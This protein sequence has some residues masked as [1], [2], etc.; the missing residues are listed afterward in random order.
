MAIITVSRQMG[1]GG[2]PI[3]QSIAKA[4]R[5]AYMDKE[6]LLADLGK[7]GGPWAAWEKEMDEVCPTLWERFDRSFA[8]LVALVERSM[9]EA[10]LENNVV[11]V[12]RGAN[13]LLRGIP[14]AFHMQ[15]VG[16]LD[17]RVEWVM[18]HYDVPRDAAVK[19]IRKIDHDRGCYLQTVYHVD[20]NNP[21]E[22][23]AV[24]DVGMQSQEQIV[25]SVL[26]RIGS[27]NSDCSDAARLILQQRVQAA[28]LKAAIL[29]DAHLFVPTLEVRH[30]G[31]ALEVSGVIHNAKQYKQIEEIVHRA[32]PGAPVDLSKLHLPD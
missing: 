32:V 7:A 23:D 24:F 10:A 20:W 26:D 31:M 25:K 17:F 28:R 9:L 19:L 21:R 22:Y 1:T 30:S 29:S 27:R 11:I 18:R 6:N 14:H 3:A 15:I 4:A 5:Y 13:V 12:G 16:P 8:G 2:R